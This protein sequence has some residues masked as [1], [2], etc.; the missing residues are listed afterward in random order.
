MNLQTLKTWIIFQLSKNS[1][2]F[3]LSF[4]FYSFSFICFS[5]NAIQISGNATLKVTQGTSFYIDGDL[6]IEHTSQI[7]NDGTINLKGNLDSKS[8]HPTAFSGTGKYIFSGDQTQFIFGN[9]PV[10]FFQLELNKL[11]PLKINVDVNIEDELKFVKGTIGISNGIVVDLGST[12]FLRHESNSSY[13]SGFGTLRATRSLNAPNNADPANMGLEITSAQNLGST[14]IE[15]VHNPQTVAQ[16]NTG[17]ERYFNISPTNNTNLNASVR[18]HYFP[19]ELNGLVENT[20]T[21]WRSVDN[22]TTWTSEGGVPHVGNKYVELTGID[23]F[24][25]WTLAD[26]PPPLPIELLDF[27]AKANANETISLEWQTVSEINNNYFSVERSKDLQMFESIGILNAKGNGND[28]NQYAFLDRNPIFGNSYYRLKQVDLD[29]KTTYSDVKQVYL[30]KENAISIFPNQLTNVS[31]TLNLVG[32]NKEN[33]TLKVVSITGQVLEIQQL[34]KNQNQF[35]IQPQA[36]GF[37]F[38]IIQNGNQIIHQE[39]IIFN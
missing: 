10:N 18:F 5:Q 21:F 32:L 26:P 1:K 9:H 16:N 7:D 28:L 30:E 25:R 37:Y 36:A 38:L 6:E 23:A 2:F 33:S 24:S 15:R 27:T 20:L 11:N 39:K 13:L 29:G 3:L 14:I 22:G 12:G 4:L 8:N 19:H 17:I 31:R 35:T 34:N